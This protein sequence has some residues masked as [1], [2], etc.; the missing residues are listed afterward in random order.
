M[1]QEDYFRTYGTNG[2]FWNI[3]NKRIILEHMEQ[4]FFLEHMEQMVYFGTYGTRELFW[5]IW[6]KWFILEHME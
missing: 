6:N 2:L 1:E 5:N 3:W 4:M